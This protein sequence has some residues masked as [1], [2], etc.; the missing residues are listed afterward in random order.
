MGCRSDDEAIQSCFGFLKPGRH[1]PFILEAAKDMGNSPSSTAPSSNVEPVQSYYALLGVTPEVA[2]DDLRRAYRRLALLHHPDKNVGKEEAATQAF[3]LIQH[4]YQVLSDPQERAWYDRH[5]AQME[6]AAAAGSGKGS[7]ASVNAEQLMRFFSPAVFDG[8]TDSPKGFFAVYRTVFEHLE[9]LEDGQD[10]AATNFGSMNTPFEPSL[11]AFYDKWLAFSTRRA[12][13]AVP[14][15]VY[16]E[17]YNAELN[18]RDRRYLEKERERQRE[19]AKREYNDVVRNLT[20]F[21]RKRDPRYKTYLQAKRAQGKL[22]A[23]AKQE[24]A[25]QQKQQAVYVEQDWTKLDSDEEA[26]LE[27]LERLEVSASDESEDGSDEEEELFCAACKKTFKSHRQWKNH[28]QSKKHIVELARYAPTSTTEIDVVS[29]ES[30]GEN[31]ESQIRETD[32]PALY[33]A[34]PKEDF[35]APE[36]PKPELLSYEET[37]QK[38][39]KKKERMKATAPPAKPAPKK[40]SKKKE[41]SKEPNEF[42]CVTC[43]TAFGS[44]NQ[45]F[46][47]L[48]ESGHAK[49]S[50]SSNS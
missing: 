41:K 23:R 33:E 21:V 8:F 50:R 40:P 30:T 18:R 39:P 45:L 14:H 24:Q 5:R 12:D 3:A 22:D 1:T 26:L 10:Y 31:D 48:K 34:N 44:R 49:Q 38:P 17:H 2:P 42:A 37:R 32:G 29:S 25:K 36:L 16:F 47:H 20:A 7:G 43:K 13:F 11:H 28:E 6:R 46:A 4:A 9:M 19:T 15:D 27:R 35:I